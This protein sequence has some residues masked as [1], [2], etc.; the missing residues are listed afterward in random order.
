MADLKPTHLEF[1]RLVAKGHKAVD[2]YC[3]AF[4]QPKGKAATANA[5]RLRA[6]LAVTAQIMAFKEQAAKDFSEE[7][8]WGVKESIREIN[9]AHE[10][11]RSMQQPGTMINAVKLKAQ[12][13]GLLTS[14]GADEEA[15]QTPEQVAEQFE[16]FLD[17]I[18]L[19][20]LEEA[21]RKARERLANPKAKLASDLANA[22]MSPPPDEDDEDEEP[23]PVKAKP[24][25][26]APV[27][28][29]VK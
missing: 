14:G 7:H 8:N 22:K 6:N 19:E 13:K 23:E 15:I 26:P 24:R 11:A 17:S 5:S 25:A 2:A 12:I 4:G 28:K 9:E 10:I 27:K 21:C 16:G 18:P 29:A 1:A 3:S 20:I